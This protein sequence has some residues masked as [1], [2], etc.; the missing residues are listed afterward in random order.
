[1]FQYLFSIFVLACTS[2]EVLG[3]DPLDTEVIESNASS[4]SGS[5]QSL[6]LKTKILQPMDLRD[7]FK[8]PFPDKTEKNESK[9][10]IING[11]VSNSQKLESINL[12]TILVTGIVILSQ[13]NRRAVVTTKGSS[14]S[15]VV[16]KEGDKIA[17]G[18]VTLKAIKEKTLLFIEEITN[19]YGQKEILETK[20]PLSD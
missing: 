2:L 1:V 19:V 6:E 10:S 11:T 18:K 12:D 7:P 8:P 13:T 16:I 4:K 3:N 9:L 15:P 5:L 20:V 17:E 14:D